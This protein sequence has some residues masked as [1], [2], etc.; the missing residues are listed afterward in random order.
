MEPISK[1][2][3]PSFLNPC[4]LV[5]GSRVD[6]YFLSWYASATTDTA[7]KLRPL[8]YNALSIILRNIQA[9]L[10][11]VTQSLQRGIDPIQMN[12]LKLFESSYP[13]IP[14]PIQKAPFSVVKIDDGPLD[15]SVKGKGTGHCSGWRWFWF[16]LEKGIPETV[17]IFYCLSF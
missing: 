3:P 13:P 4:S 9:T 5:G 17:F 14:L 15:L 1:P 16:F 8:S 11:N 6:C 12:V 10:W 7:F 2:P